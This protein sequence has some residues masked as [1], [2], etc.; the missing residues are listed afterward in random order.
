MRDRDF[1]SVADALRDSVAFR[2]SRSVIERSASAA[3]ESAALN[4]MR[5]ITR[6]FAAL[7]VQRQI[8]I[9]A[10]TVAIASLAH[11]AI[12][13]LLPR[14]ATSGLPWWWSMTFAGF[15][16]IVAMLARPIASASPDS[17]PA[18]LWRRFTA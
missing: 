4:R 8:Q 16:V 13:E 17:T 9:I 15:A 14:Y 1:D 18:K 11:L 6:A 7:T 3:G 2:A 12:R 5:E 10:L